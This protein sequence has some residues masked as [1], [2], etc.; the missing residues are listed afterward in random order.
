MTVYLHDS[1]GT[2]IAFRTETNGRYLFNPDGAWIGWFPWGDDEAVSQD[3]AYLGTIVGD[4]L[5]LRD[6]PPY[7][8]TP[9]HPGAPP[10]PGQA[11]YPGAAAYHSLPVGF[12]DVPGSALW[13][14]QRWGDSVA[15]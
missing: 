11:G 2:W 7:R 14:A 5:L 10:Y 6:A 4:R 1:Q 12:S 3:G 9:S 15:S 8:G 13:P